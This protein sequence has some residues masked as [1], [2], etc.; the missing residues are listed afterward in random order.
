MLLVPVPDATGSEWRVPESEE[1][2]SS[3][4]A[5]A[6][7]EAP[8]LS[9]AGARSPVLAQARSALIVLAILSI[10]VVVQLTFV[11]SWVHRSAQVSLFNRFRTELA[12]GTGPIGASKPLL[13]IGA[14]MALIDIP[15]IGV[16]QVVVEGTTSSVLTSGPGHLRS[17]VFP[18]G[19][20]NSV[21][22]GRAAAFGG[23]F[24]RIHTL[25]RGARITVTTQVGV[26]NFR[27]VGVR[28]AGGKITQLAGGASRLTL[29]TASGTEYIPSGVVSVI[30]DKV[31]PPLASAAPPVSAVSASELPLGTDTSTLWAL[32]F[33][34]EAL[35]VVMAV[36]V[37]T[38]RRR[39]HAQAWIVFTAPLLLIWLFIAGQIARLL[40]NLL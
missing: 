21:I 40:P 7:A 35:A 15:S 23:P 10:G 25:R 20:G 2:R 18:G 32:V 26:S 29:Q 31:G 27:V 9:G 8:G 16:K 13:P 11:S 12:L 36:A 24:G 5:A 19:A 37:W 28:Y 39:G 33:W 1:V 17:T 6:T 14:P 30:A 22:L 3:H 4:R 38:W 34:L